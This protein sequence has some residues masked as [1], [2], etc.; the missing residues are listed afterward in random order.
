MDGQ[1]TT[2]MKLLPFGEP[3]LP[4]GEPL[5]IGSYESNQMTANVMAKACRTCG[6]T[7]WVSAPSISG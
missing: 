7:R 1:K 2:E 6:S 5:F 3:L 4:F